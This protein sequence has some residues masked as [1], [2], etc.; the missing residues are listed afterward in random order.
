MSL[1]AAIASPINEIVD[2]LGPNDL[3]YTIPIHP[4][5]VHLT[6]GLF[7][8][9]IAFDF[10]GAFYPLEKRVFRFLAL[11]VT[12]TGFHDVGWY[13]VLACSIFTFFTVA[14][15][16]YEMLLAVP[17]PGVK[18]ILGQGAITTM[19]WH[20]VGGVALLLIIVAMTIWRGYQRFVW[21]KDLG[22]QVSW[23]YLAC[24]VL[25]LLLMGVH[26]SLGAWLA[27]EFGVHITADQLIASGANLSEVLP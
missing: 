24:G 27:S 2:S 13:N 26:G 23:I 15:G 10:A 8:I 20:A 4:N 6:I 9:G 14:A 12:R 18:T 16:F 11:P 19:L 22:R 17:L 7:S 5:L 21:R 3:P 1:L 25:I